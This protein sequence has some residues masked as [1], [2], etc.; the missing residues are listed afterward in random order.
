MAKISEYVD[1]SEVPN[2][3][4]GTATDCEIPEGGTVPNSKKKG[5]AASAEGAAEAPTVR[6]DG[7]MSVCV[8]AGTIEDSEFPDVAAGSKVAFVAKVEAYVTLTP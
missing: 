6:E 8:A 2:W 1:P 3:L 7:F 5:G 4:G